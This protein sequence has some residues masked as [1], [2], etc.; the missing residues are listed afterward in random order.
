MNIMLFVLKRCMCWTACV[1]VC[2]WAEE[3]FYWVI[4]LI[5]IK[6]VFVCVTDRAWVSKDHI[7]LDQNYCK[8]AFKVHTHT[9]TICIGLL[10]LFLSLVVPSIII[11]IVHIRL[12]C[13]PPTPVSP[14]TLKHSLSV[15]FLFLT[16]TCA[17]F[18]LLSRQFSLWTVSAEV[19][20]KKKKRWKLPTVTC[21]YYPK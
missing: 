7:L 11:Y 16:H 13:Y 21:V 4:L 19:K 3:S 6:C 2:M 9:Q 18:F 14:H 5:K 8:I 12:L 1:Y 15:S 10:W 20:K 17:L